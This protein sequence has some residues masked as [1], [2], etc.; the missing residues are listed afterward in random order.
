MKWIVSGML[1]GI[2]ALPLMGYILAVQWL[3]AARTMR[4]AGHR[5]A[6]DQAA[7]LGATH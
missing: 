4:R 3:D 7:G 5:P 1:T 2:L 6:L